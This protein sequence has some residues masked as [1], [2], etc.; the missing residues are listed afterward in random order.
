MIA[1]IY[2]WCRTRFN[3]LFK[4]FQLACQKSNYSVSYQKNQSIS[5]YKD[6]VITILKIIFF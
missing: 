5:N 2:V 1:S 3:T 4:C 6:L